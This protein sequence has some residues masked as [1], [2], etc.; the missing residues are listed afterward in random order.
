MQAQSGRMTGPAL[1]AL[2]EDGTLAGHW[3]LDPLT[4]SIR[5]KTK[6]MGPIRVNGVFRDVSGHGSVSPDG[7]VSGA[8]TVAVA[9][10]DTRN[11]RRDSHLRSAEIFDSGNHP[12]ITFTVYS[13]RPLAPGVGVT[14][15]LTVRDCTRP[16]SF[17]VAVASS[18]GNGEVWLDGEISINRADFSI[19]WKFDGLASATSTLTIHAVFTRR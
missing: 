6:S 4:S 12:N 8:L 17:P 9:S 5:L 11:T 18:P 7:E 19:A 10:I 2:L 16:L 14:G 3:V 13:I 15:A 1:R